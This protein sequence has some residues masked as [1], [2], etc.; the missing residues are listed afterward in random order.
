MKNLSFDWNKKVKDK[1]KKVTDGE[2][3]DFKKITIAGY[4]TQTVDKNEN[5][6]GIIYYVKVRIL[7]NVMSDKK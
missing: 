7:N 6:S 2:N 1:L 5:E 4:K 3:F